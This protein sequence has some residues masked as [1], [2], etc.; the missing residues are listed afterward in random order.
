MFPGSGPGLRS[1]VTRPAC[2]G[3]P[4]LTGT[5]ASGLAMMIGDPCRVMRQKTASV[6]GR[7]DQSRATPPT[8]TRLT[9]CVRSPCRDRDRWQHDPR[10]P[11][12]ADH[13]RAGL[14]LRSFLRSGFRIGA[15]HPA[16]VPDRDPRH[17]RSLSWPTG[18]SVHSRRRRTPRSL[19]AR[20][21]SLRQT[22]GYPVGPGRRAR[23][24]ADCRD[25]LDLAVGTT[26]T[27]G[28]KVA[29]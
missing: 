26:S 3:R 25:V 12:R 16:P 13:L 20:G 8:S 7:T 1:R 28:G 17:A 11:R 4:G 24:S 15:D 6:S 23:P 14:P 21:A 10:H 5:G 18:P 22:V 29:T 9:L 19:A 27:D 2:P